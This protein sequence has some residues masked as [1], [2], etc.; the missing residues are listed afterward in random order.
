MQAQAVGGELSL[1]DDSNRPPTNNLSFPD[2]YF[3][4]GYGASAAVIEGGTWRCAAWENRIALPYVERHIESDN[5]DAVSPYGYCGLHVAPE[6]SE[7][8]LESF[9]SSLRD[10]W[11]TTGLV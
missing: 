1:F 3:T 9:W 7:R 4:A 5:F 6:C 11:R 2:V 8:E 10:Y